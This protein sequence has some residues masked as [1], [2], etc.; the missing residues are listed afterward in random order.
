[1]WKAWPIASVDIYM[2]KG[3]NLGVFFFQT[4]TFIRAESVFGKKC[5]SKHI[6][7]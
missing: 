4:F 5:F 7:N 3:K 1:M 6:P 2:T